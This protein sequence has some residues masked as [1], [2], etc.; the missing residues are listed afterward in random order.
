MKFYLGSDSTTRISSDIALSWNTATNG[1][2]A[3]DIGI[4][5]GAIGKLYV[6]NGVQG[7]FTGILIAGQAGIGTTTPT[8]VL[9]LKAGTAGVNTAPLKFTLP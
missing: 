8:A 1:T 4:S 3:N 6:G 7:D 5:R 2:G 9:Q